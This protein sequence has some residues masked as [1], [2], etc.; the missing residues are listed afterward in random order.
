MILLALSSNAQEPQ[1]RLRV[2]DI[3]VIPPK[4]TFTNSTDSTYFALPRYRLQK[5]L[6][7]SQ[8]L[9]TVQAVYRRSIDE[10]VRECESLE[11]GRN[12]WRLAAL[13]AGAVVAGVVIAR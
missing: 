2:D 9:D 7:D 13:A 1:G 3:F 6:V 8:M 11:R 5:L 12:F 10:L 4:L